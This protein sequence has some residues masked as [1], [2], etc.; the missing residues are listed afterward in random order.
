MADYHILAADK[1]GNKFNIVMHFPV[2]D[3]INEAGINY[4]TAIVEWQ[5]G[6]PIQSVLTNIGTEQTQLDSGELYERSYS[7]SSNPGETPA[8]K[9]VRL[10]DM[11]NEKKTEVQAELIKVL[12]YWG[13]SRT[14]P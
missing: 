14:I 1:Y 8:Q 6:A 12:S 9:Q 2:S 5:G 7:F 4:R 11:W 10:D 13:F 3:T